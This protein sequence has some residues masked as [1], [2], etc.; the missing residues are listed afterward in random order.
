MAQDICVP[1]G[2]GLVNVRVGAII[3]KDGKLLMVHHEAGD[4]Y[5]SV[6]GRIQFGESAQEAIV[7]EVKEETGLTMEV[8]GLGFVHENFFTADS[9]SKM[10]LPVY[11]ISFF[12]F[13]KLP[14][15]GDLCCASVNEDGLPE[16]IQW[17][18]PKSEVT[19]YP[20]FFR[21]DLGQPGDGVKH[22]F[23]D[24]RKAPTSRFPR[25]IEK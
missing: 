22:C 15:G 3:R 8:E 10:G 16:K 2:E 12:F 20:D 25:K 6:G 13:M 23:T 7:R 18:D 17:V 19:I 9:R 24:E 21:N 1:C 11:E 5:Y 14:E 4:Y